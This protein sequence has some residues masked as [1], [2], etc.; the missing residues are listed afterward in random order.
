MLAQ[1]AQPPVQCYFLR[2]APGEIWIIYAS[3][4]A[5]TL[6]L[7]FSRLQP[8]KPDARTHTCNRAWNTCSTTNSL[9]ACTHTTSLTQKPARARAL[10]HSHP[11][12]HSSAC[13]TEYDPDTQYTAV[14]LWCHIM[15]LL[16]RQKGVTFA[17][18]RALL[19]I[20]SRY[21]E[22]STVRTMHAHI[23]GPLAVLLQRLETGKFT[24]K[25]THDKY[26]G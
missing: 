25:H 6:L 24:K 12:S 19:H 7:T 13:Q 3:L 8:Q 5:H 21:V 4:H 15:S 11:W 14:H 23:W 10:N 22:L 1:R 26:I 2:R 9:F 18:R 20:L 17:E 16:W